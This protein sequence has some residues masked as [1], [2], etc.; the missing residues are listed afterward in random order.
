MRTIHED[1]M[2]DYREQ[3]REERYKRI[4]RSRWLDPR[5]PDYISPEAWCQ[6]CETFTTN[7][8]RLGCCTVCGKEVI[9]D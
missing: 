2:A 4:Q 9:K 3:A 5:D 8:D 6:T 1:E 7:I